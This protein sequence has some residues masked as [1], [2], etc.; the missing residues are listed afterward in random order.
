ME[1]VQVEATTIGE[2]VAALEVRFPGIAARLTQD[3]KLRHGIVVAVDGVAFPRGLRQRLTAPS[4][5]H[6][7]PA[8]AGG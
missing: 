1:R 4:E 6:F 7:V 2:V 3:G 5:I 8:L